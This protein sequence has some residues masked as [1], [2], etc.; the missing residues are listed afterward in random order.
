MVG[1]ALDTHVL[2][3]ITNLGGLHIFAL[4]AQMY[5]LVLICFDILE[6]RCLFILC[7]YFSSQTCK[8]YLPVVQSCVG[9][10][11]HVDGCEGA[12]SKARS[13]TPPRARRSLCRLLM[14]YANS[15]GITIQRG[16]GWL[17]RSLHYSGISIGSESSCSRLSCS[18]VGS[19]GFGDGLQP[20]KRMR[21]WCCLVFLQ[22]CIRH[23]RLPVFCPLFFFFRVFSH[24]NA[25]NTPVATNWHPCWGLLVV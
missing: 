23:R 12:E 22:R 16:V 11:T 1:H 7:F 20:Q 8:V 25:L 17:I 3:S 4:M 9:L 19:C 21:F 24:R 2:V 18:P 13:T 10:C 6:S 14:I 15:S 5:I